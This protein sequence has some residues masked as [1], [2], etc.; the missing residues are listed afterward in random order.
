MK[1][2][3]ISIFTSYYTWIA[4]ELIIIA[5]LVFFVLK[6]SRRKKIKTQ[7]IE[8]RELAFQ[9]KEL[10]EMLTNKKRNRR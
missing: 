9:Y 1:D 10:D 3:L 4:I 5:V 2:T 8:K 7:D 6:Y